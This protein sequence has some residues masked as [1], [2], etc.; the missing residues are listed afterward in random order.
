M[1]VCC[2]IMVATMMKDDDEGRGVCGNVYR[3]AGMV[4][5]PRML[6]DPDGL[7][8]VAAFRADK[9]CYVLHTLYEPP[10]H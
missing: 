4:G 6:G 8:P 1:T 10:A 7:H 2:L 5:A 3:E 9:V